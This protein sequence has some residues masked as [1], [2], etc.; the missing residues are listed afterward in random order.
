MQQSHWWPPISPPVHLQ[1][2]QHSLHAL[3][4][5]RDEQ[6][7]HRQAPMAGHSERNACLL[8]SPTRGQRPGQPK[9]AAC[10]RHPITPPHR[11]PGRP[12][13]AAAR[14]AAGSRPAA[15]QTWRA[16]GHPESLRAGARRPVVTA[17]AGTTAVGHR[18]LLSLAAVCV[19]AKAL[20]AAHSAA[21]LRCSRTFAAVSEQPWHSRSPAVRTAMPGAYR[22]EAWLAQ[23]WR[24][25]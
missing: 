16:C 25:A 11:S 15:P 7:Q 5:T 24:C 6:Q 12:S 17:A 22:D 21:M 1:S 20:A 8:S 4:E 13:R 19:R 3:D 18:R 9:L 14:R 2:R 23:G 10:R